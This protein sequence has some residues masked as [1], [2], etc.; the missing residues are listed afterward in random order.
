[1][2]GLR[3]KAWQ[4][5][6]LGRS[7][8]S[9]VSEN[10]TELSELASALQPSPALSPGTPSPGRLAGAECPRVSQ[11]G[12]ET[13]HFRFGGPTGCVKSSQPR[14]GGEEAV[15]GCGPVPMTLERQK[16]PWARLSPGPELADSRSA[17][18]KTHFRNTDVLLCGFFLIPHIRDA[19]QHFSFCLLRRSLRQSPGPPTG[20]HTALLRAFR[21][22]R[23][24]HCVTTVS[25]VPTHLLVGV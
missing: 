19:V 1:M 9:P 18:G 3:V 8:Q 11:I 15:L 24:T 21:R 12:P 16:E 17:L 6:C 22:L 14:C 2:S 10:R 7:W 23:D 25:S 13:Q 20:L 4:Q 5:G